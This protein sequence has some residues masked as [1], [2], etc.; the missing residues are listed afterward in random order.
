MY[1]ADGKRASQHLVGHKSENL[2]LHRLTKVVDVERDVSVSGTS[3]PL[4]GDG[5]E[6]ILWRRSGLARE[7][8]VAVLAAAIAQYPVLSGELIG[9]VWAL[10]VVEQT[11]QLFYEREDLIRLVE[12]G[13]GHTS[14]VPEGL[15]QRQVLGRVTTKYL[16]PES[17]S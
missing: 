3:T 17:C 4:R 9:R 13:T 1:C 6:R 2:K 11:A 12:F 14:S 8:P 7:N 16:S 15:N 5:I 10:V